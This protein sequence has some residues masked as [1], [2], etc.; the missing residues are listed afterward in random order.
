MTTLISN[1]PR[2]RVPHHPAHVP[3]PRKDHWLT[4][5]YVLLS[6]RDPVLFSERNGYRR[7]LFGLM[8]WRILEAYQ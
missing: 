7:R 3:P 6:P 8:G 2:L 5:Q 4:R 1:E